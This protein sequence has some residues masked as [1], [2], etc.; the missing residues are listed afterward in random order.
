VQLSLTVNPYIRRYH[1][2]KPLSGLHVVQVWDITAGKEI[3]N[4]SHTH[5]LTAIQFSPT[6]FIL[7]TACK[8][9]TIRFWDLD[10]FENF[11][12]CGP[13]ATS[14]HATCFRSDG[15]AVLA[16]YQDSL[17][18]YTYD[19]AGMLQQSEAQWGHVADM[20]VVDERLV[21]CSLNGP[22][23]SVWYA[24]T[25]LPA[26]ASAAAPVAAPTP[27][28]GKQWAGIS[29]AAGE[30][31][32]SGGGGEDSAALPRAGSTSDEQRSNAGVAV[33]ALRKGVGNLRVE[34]K[35]TATSS[36]STAN[37][38]Q[39]CCHESSQR[40]VSIHGRDTLLGET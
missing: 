23:V 6:E 25:T 18:T 40:W 13:E 36:V 31:R 30:G 11:D 39:V 2:M 3:A 38:L 4:F 19:P 37:D 1:I 15:A 27:E 33:A 32:V 26:P 16:A 29:S 35:G 14:A 5:P 7:A 22:T 12:T 28:S 9:R 8:D 24:S 10:D 21:A 34:N 17:K 20:T